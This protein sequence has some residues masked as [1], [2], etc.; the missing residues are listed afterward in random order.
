MQSGCSNEKGE[1]ERVRELDQNYDKRNAK[2]KCE[3]LNHSW[4]QIRTL[5][6]NGVRLW[7]LQTVREFV[8]KFAG[9]KLNVALLELTDD[10]WRGVDF[11]WDKCPNESGRFWATFKFEGAES[12]IVD[13]DSWDDRGLPSQI[14]CVF[15]VC[16]DI[17]CGRCLLRC[18]ECVV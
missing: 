16:F 9:A 4:K 18:S 17:L 2:D 13:F 1:T 7:Q 12:V 8:L 14:S 6:S 3:C 10:R 11:C 5:Q 15:G